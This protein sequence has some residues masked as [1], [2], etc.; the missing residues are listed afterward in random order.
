MASGGRH[1]LAQSIFQ[2]GGNAGSAAGPLL[3]ALI[4]IPHGQHSVGW[5]AL[6]ALLAIAVLWQVG[7]WYALASRAVRTRAKERAKP[8]TRRRRGAGHRR[9]VR[10]CCC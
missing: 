7:G 8:G 2:V 10:C 4:V 1:G 9:R 3:A 6:A 5:F